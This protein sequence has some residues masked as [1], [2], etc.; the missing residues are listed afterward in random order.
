[1]NATRWRRVAVAILT[2]LLIGTLVTLGLLQPTVVAI[3][4]VAVGTAV[5]FVRSWDRKKRAAGVLIA[6]SAV[7]VLMPGVSRL[8][9]A[10]ASR[11][12]S[13]L[14]RG[15]LIDIVTDANPGMPWCWAVLTLQKTNGNGSDVLVARRGTVSL[16]PGVWPATTCTSARLSASWST[17]VPASNAIVW[18][19]EWQ[20]DI[21]RLRELSAS[22]CRVRAWLQFGRVPYL[23]EGAILDLRYETPIAQN[24]TPMTID[25]DLTD[26][27]IFLTSWVPPRA[28]VLTLR[29]NR[30]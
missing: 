20:V 11:A 15:E 8:A 29:S 22:N 3:M 24:F 26:C 18:H 5:F 16:M 27:P 23:S 28:D 13:T 30:P 12:A 2:L 10:E 17:D 21:G 25:S 7:F 9:K 4:L 14:S 19:R 6:T 1:M